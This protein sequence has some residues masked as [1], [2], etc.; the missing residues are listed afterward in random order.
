MPRL[1]SGMFSSVSDA[2]LIIA[3][4]AYA[5]EDT[6]ETASDGFN[7]SLESQA[8]AAETASSGPPVEE[9]DIF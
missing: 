1:I 7:S 3:A 6:P 9:N 4:N 2:Q 5:E 8:A